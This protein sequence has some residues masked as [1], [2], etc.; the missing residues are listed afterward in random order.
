VSD[1]T[2]T[3]GSASYKYGDDLH[4]QIEDMDLTVL[5]EPTLAALRAASQYWYATEMAEQL[6]TMLDDGD[7][8]KDEAEAA[9]DLINQARSC[10]YGCD[11]AELARDYAVE[12]ADE[13]LKSWSP[14]VCVQ[15]VATPGGGTHYDESQLGS[16]DM[17]DLESLANY[18]SA[19]LGPGLFGD[20]SVVLTDGVLTYTADNGAN[21]H[22]TKVV[23]ELIPLAGV[24]LET[25]KSVTMA[26]HGTNGVDDG[27]ANW[28]YGQKPEH[29]AIAAA[30]MVAIS[31][32]DVSLLDD[33]TTADDV[34]KATIEAVATLGLDAVA[35]LDAED[36][37]LVFETTGAV[38]FTA[39]VF[40]IA[41]GLSLAPALTAC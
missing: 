31:E 34:A 22:Y 23:I 16:L 19:A 15:R 10:E 13:L 9:Q 39:D 18:Q 6:Q 26:L 1:V 12:Q 8:P 7:V 20:F 24:L 36:V 40:I 28:L 30:V 41:A 35:T 5:S 2:N 3:T 37:A 33:Q 32:A 21:Y 25:W 38:T 14:V 11:C 4:T 27:I 17:E 29:A